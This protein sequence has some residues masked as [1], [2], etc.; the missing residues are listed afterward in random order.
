MG[1]DQDNEEHAL[2]AH[3][4]MLEFTRAYKTKLS[5]EVRSPR[6]SAKYWQS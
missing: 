4:A 3:H 2:L 5:A 1:I 6:I